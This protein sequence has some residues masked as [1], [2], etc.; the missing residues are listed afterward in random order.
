MPTPVRL[1][2][3]SDWRGAARATTQTAPAT[4]PPGDD[5][6]AESEWRAKYGEK[7]VFP[8]ILLSVPYHSCIKTASGQSLEQLSLCA[9][10]LSH[11][12]AAAVT[13]LAAGRLF[14][15]S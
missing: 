14:G 8:H 4:L 12:A 6:R 9:A 10:L 2:K 3:L 1:A 15:V 13:A 11:L 7:Y 5:A